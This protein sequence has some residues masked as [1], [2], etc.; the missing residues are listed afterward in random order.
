VLCDPRNA[1]AHENFVAAVRQR[2]PGAP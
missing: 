2:L 1:P